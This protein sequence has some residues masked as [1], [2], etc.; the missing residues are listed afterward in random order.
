[1]GMSDATKP[2]WQT[3]E[4]QSEGRVNRFNGVQFPRTRRAEG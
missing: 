3:I 4:F 2:S 1:M